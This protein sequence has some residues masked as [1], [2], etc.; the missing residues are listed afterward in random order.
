[1]DEVYSE[2]R[3]QLELLLKKRGNFDPVADDQSI[4]L[5]G[6]LDS[7]STLTLLFFLE[8]HYG[9]RLAHGDL[10]IGDVDSL[11]ALTQA[12]RSRLS[13]SKS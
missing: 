3:S 10:S 5:S 13:I 9:F 7:I 4:F 11:N 8:D 1:M 2:I 12:V 6:L